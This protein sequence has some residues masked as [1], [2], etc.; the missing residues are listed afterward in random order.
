[1]VDVFDK[2]KLL[3]AKRT[4]GLSRETQRPILASLGRPT[5]QSWPPWHGQQLP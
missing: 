1:V 5:D 2:E 4:P 3:Q